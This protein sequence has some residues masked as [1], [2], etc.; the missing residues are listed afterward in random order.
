VKTQTLDSGLLLLDLT[1]EEHLAVSRSVKAV[2]GALEPCQLETAFGE[3]VDFA[4]EFQ[5]SVYLSEAA[6]RMA[7]I[8]WLPAGEVSDTF[9]LVQN[10]RPIVDIHFDRDGALWRVNDRQLNFIE[11]IVNFHSGRYVR[12]LETA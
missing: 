10:V 3:S 9:A 12:P 11:A 7:G 6:A 4:Y 8:A 1:V 2:M 5:Y